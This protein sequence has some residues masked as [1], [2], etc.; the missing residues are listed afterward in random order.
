VCH[1]KCLQKEALLGILDVANIPKYRGA[2]HMWGSTCIPRKVYQVLYPLKRHFGCAQAQHFLICCWLLLALIR[3]PGKGT[4][5][6]LA[7][8]LPA[9]LTY[10]TT[11]RMVRSGQWDAAA[12]VC[13]LAT[14]TLRTLPA[15]GDGVLYLI[16]DST[17][18][19]KRGRKHPVGRTTRHSDH[20]PYIFGFEVGLLIASWERLR[21][22]VALA[23]IDP[24]IK[25]HQ[26]LRF[27]QRLKDFVPP[28]WVRQI[29]VVAD[30]GFAANATM[31]LIPE[32]HYGSVF[33]MPRTRKFT[34]GKHR[35]DLVSHLP[36]SCYYRRASAK[37]DGRRQDYWVFV[38]HATLHK[39]GDV[40]IVLSKKRRNMG[41]KQVKMLVTN[42]TEATA[43][44]ILS[45]Y[46]RRWGVELTIQELKSGLHL[47]RM[48]VT[49]DKD[50]VTR[51]VALSVL[52]YLLLVRLYG[53]DEAVMQDW[54]LFKLKERFIGEVAQDAVQRTERKWQHK[55]KQFKDVA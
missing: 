10:W 28:A 7:P 17:V 9:T 45:I 32:K 23:L 6:G 40:T 1:V 41:P 54:S 33:A 47:G 43:G 16:G 44:T 35:R 48:P 13:D 31:R 8:Y 36:K 29:I 27:R 5:K 49:N 25:G 51:S 12:G 19:E 14:A 18:K 3:D 53:S 15:P 11:M 39:L 37:P 26:N 22:P 50:R 46:A 24:K 21:V 4:L 55:L 30:A 34:N 42:L 38:R 52:A 20:A 2:Q